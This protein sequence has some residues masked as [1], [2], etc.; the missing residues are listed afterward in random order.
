MFPFENSYW[1]Y[2]LGTVSETATE[3]GGGRIENFSFLVESFS[4]DCCE[5]GKTK[6]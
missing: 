5:E 3:I 4:W 2:M 1:V 6:E